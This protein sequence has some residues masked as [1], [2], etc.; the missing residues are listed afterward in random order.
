[1]SFLKCSSIYEVVPVF[2]RAFWILDVTRNADATVRTNVK[3]IAFLLGLECSYIFFGI[4]SYYSDQQLVVT[5]SELLNRGLNMSFKLGFIFAIIGRF[6]FFI[7][8]H[9]FWKIVES[10]KQCDLLVRIFKLF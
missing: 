3:N 8:R 4:Y 10:M 9:K 2:Q 7:L 6:I 1:M 5:A